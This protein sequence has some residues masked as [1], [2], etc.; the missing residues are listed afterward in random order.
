MCSTVAAAYVR[1]VEEQLRQRGREDLLFI[2]CPVSGGAKRAADGTLTIMAGASDG[3]LNRGR[4]LLQEMSDPKKLFLCGGIGTGSGMKMA[5][6][7][8]AGIQ[9]LATSEAMGLSSMLGTNPEKVRNAILKSDGWSW[10]YENRVQRMLVED[11]Y[12]GVSALAIILKDVVSDFVR[13][14]EIRELSA[15][16]GYHNPFSARR[17]VSHASGLR[18][19]T[20]LRLGV[21][22]RL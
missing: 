6:Q 8:L 20:D 5:H 13:M 22:A 12:P 10:M 16:T 4:I 18:C 9:I 2:D 15:T 11:Y 7:V 14:G 19:G 1:S 3:A 21:D 17:E